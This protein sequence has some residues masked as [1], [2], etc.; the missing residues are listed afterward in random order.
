MLSSSCNVVAV[1]SNVAGNKVGA[2]A[3]NWYFL[4][5]VFLRHR[6]DDQALDHVCA[7]L[8]WVVIGL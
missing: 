8:H 6:L 3:S 4:M 5:Q 2:V 7:I 1:G